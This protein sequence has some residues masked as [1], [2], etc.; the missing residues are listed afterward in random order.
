MYQDELFLSY[1][2]DQYSTLKNLL[3]RTIRSIQEQKENIT[4][5]ELLAHPN[6]V[7]VAHLFSERTIV[8]AFEHPILFVNENICGSYACH[9]YWSFDDAVSLAAGIDP[10]YLDLRPK[11]CA[12]TILRL[13]LARK[14]LALYAVKRGELVSIQ[15]DN[16]LWLQP[17]VF[18]SWAIAND[19]VSQSSSK[20]FEQIMS[21]RPER[22][23]DA[24]TLSVSTS[25]SPKG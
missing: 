21:L 15:K 14:R 12:P 1:P 16:D 7:R 4:I 13:R 22:I 6:I 25:L 9:Q 18:C 10:L 23:T 20:L 3:Y 17:H 2:F 5:L 11:G 8:D 19:L 24:D